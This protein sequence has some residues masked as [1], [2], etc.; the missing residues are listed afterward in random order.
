MDDSGKLTRNEDYA[1]FAGI[2][3]RNNSEKAKFVNRYKSIVKD[4]KCNY[5][6]QNANSCNKDCPEIKGIIISKSDRRRVLNIGKE[7][8]TFGVVIFNKDVFPQILAD[9][10]SKGRYTEYAQRRIV[11]RCISRLISDG[12]I[13]PNLPVYLHIGIDEMPTKTNGYYSL[14]DGLTEELRYG[15]INYNYEKRFTPILHNDLKIDVIY[16]DSRHNYSIQFSD[17]LANSIRRSFVRNPNWYQTK[18][19][20]LDKLKL[21]ELM[22]LPK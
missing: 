8:F 21:N 6:D 15:I 7:Y 20:L 14:K 9:P 3:F 17:I 4:I 22:S 16:Y 1:I 10:L 11:K 12:S 18:Q 2:L 5:C 13:D 19:Y